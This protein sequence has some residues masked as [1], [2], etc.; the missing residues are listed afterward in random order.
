[1]S[2]ELVDSSLEYSRA[3]RAAI[4]EREE[5]LTPTVEAYDTA[6]S[7]RDRWSAATELCLTASAA[8]QVYNEAV[9]LAGLRMRT[10]DERAAREA[11][12]A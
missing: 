4:K 5:A 3:I 2:D 10:R 1:V 6:V 12:E 8:D 7:S 9:I 11:G